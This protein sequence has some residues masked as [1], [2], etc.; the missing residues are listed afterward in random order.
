ML[1]HDVAL[2]ALVDVDVR[3]DRIREASVADLQAQTFDAAALVS[4]PNVSR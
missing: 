1:T 3:V 4:L 2:F